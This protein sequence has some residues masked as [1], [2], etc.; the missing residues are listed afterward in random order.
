MYKTNIITS[1]RGIIDSTLREG[2]QFRY[3]NFSLSQQKKIVKMLS[4]IGVDRIE[5]GNPVAAEIGNTIKQL[6]KM[7]HR[8]KILAHVRNKISDIKAAK[9]AGVDGVNIL[10]SIS[11]E[12][13]SKMNKTF[14]EYIAQLIEGVLYARE[15]QLEVRVSVEHFFQADKQQAI[16]VFTVAER[17][18]ANRIGIA[19]T[20]GVAMSWEVEES[21]R[22]LRHLFTTEIEVHFHNDLGQANSNA[23]SALKNG[24]NWVD[25]TL[26][27]IGERS[28]ITALSTF[29]ASMY[30]FENTMSNRYKIDL[31]TSVENSVAKMINHDVPFN[32]LTN[33]ENGFAHKAGIHL[34][35]LMNFG[36]ASYELFSPNVVGNTRQLIYGTQISGKTNAQD[37]DQFMKVYGKA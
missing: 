8:S 20:L 9:D 7:P 10:C 24:A 29:L 4:A 17:L 33:R 5:V 31:L 18:H 32:L 16:Q 36:P 12:R 30:H 13:L 21:V 26:L 11:H 22:F 19:D 23:I 3:A 6:T 14:D 25:T 1:Y 35:A 15:Q 27:G 34:N 2:Q 37:I 28:G